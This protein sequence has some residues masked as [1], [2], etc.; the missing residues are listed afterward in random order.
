MSCTR[1]SYISKCKDE[2]LTAL[3]KDEQAWR[4]RLRGKL[5]QVVDTVALSS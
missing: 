3:E 2:I 5:G 1:Y 4:Q